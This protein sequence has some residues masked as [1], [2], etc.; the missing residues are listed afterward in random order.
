MAEFL[1]HP[2]IRKALA[3]GFPSA[4][5]HRVGRCDCCG[6]VICDGDGCFCT[7]DGKLLHEDCL[8]EF[9][10]DELGTDVLATELGYERVG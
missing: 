10:L 8:V 2:A 4:L 6:E 5:P 3:S 7:D 1:E 9:V